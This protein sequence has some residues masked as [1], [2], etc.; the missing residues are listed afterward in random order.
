MLVKKTL[1]HCEGSWK[2]LTFHLPAVDGKKKMH[3]K[4]GVLV[5]EGQARF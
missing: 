5:F 1:C 4:N 3:V 2:P